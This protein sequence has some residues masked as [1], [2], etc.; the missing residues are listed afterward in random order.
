MRWK[1]RCH[2]GDFSLSQE[3]PC[4]PLCKSICFITRKSL[5]HWLQL[6]F[7]TYLGEALINIH[8]VQLRSW[9]AGTTLPG[10]SGFSASSKLPAH[11]YS[12]S[13]GG[14]KEEGKE[15]VLRAAVRILCTSGG[16]AY[17]SA[18]SCLWS[19]VLLRSREPAPLQARGQ[20]CILFLRLLR[21]KQPRAGPFSS[22]TP[23]LVLLKL[24]SK[25]W[26][27]LTPHPHSVWSWQVSCSPAGAVGTSTSSQSMN[28]AAQEMPLGVPGMAQQLSH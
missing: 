3:N 28:G 27:L 1:E 24:L 10:T 5:E 11:G 12:T 2:A 25:S 20:S 15:R 4:W 17:S 21:L 8:D 14:R 6:K 18:R 19:F 7:F 23:K 22:Y 9:K 26:R 16:A 13:I